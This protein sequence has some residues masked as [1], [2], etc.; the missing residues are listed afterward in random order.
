MGNIQVYKKIQEA[1]M[2]IWKFIKLRDKSDKTLSKNNMTEKSGRK[3]GTD[4]GNTQGERK[5]RK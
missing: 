5:V 4:Q 3:A 2:T 1:K